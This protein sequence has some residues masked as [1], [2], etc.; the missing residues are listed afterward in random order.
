MR[1]ELRHKLALA[2]AMLAMPG[3]ALLMRVM[4]Y[5]RVKKL[6]ARLSAGAPQKPSAT[7]NDP[8][9]RMT[10]QL[11]SFAAKHTLGKPSCLTRSLVLWWMLREQGLPSEMRIGERPAEAGKPGIRAH[12]WLELDGTVLNDSPTHVSAFAVF[13]KMPDLPLNAF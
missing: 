13:D 4:G 9:L 1:L 11:A 8:D 7:P 12:A 5:R 3:A 10:V 2:R 6:L